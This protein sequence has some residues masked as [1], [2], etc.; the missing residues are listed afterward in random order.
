M[1]DQVATEKDFIDGV[2][3]V[4]IMPNLV[5]LQLYDL[6]LTQQHW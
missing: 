5:P 2:N 3:K 6:Q 1:S 4:I